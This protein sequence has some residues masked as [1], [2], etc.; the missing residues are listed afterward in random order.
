MNFL[1]AGIISFFH[2]NHVSLI[3]FLSFRQLLRG[4]VLSSFGRLFIIPAILWGQAQS[5]TYLLLSEIFV[6]TS[7]IAAI[8]GMIPVFLAHL[9]YQ[10]KSLYSH[11]LSVVVAVAVDMVRHRNFIFVVNIIGGSGGMCQRMPPPT[12]PNSFIF[13][14]IFTEKCPRWRPKPPQNG[15]MP[16]LWKIL[17]P[18]LNMYT[19]P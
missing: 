15:S 4:I 10:P 8:K 16:P 5:A 12:G 9:V 7:N 14:Y 1:I 11:A 2:R 18:A 17:D 13:A 19:C 6:L 3:I